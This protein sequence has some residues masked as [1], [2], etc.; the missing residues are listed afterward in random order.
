MLDV[1]FDDDSDSDPD[2]PRDHSF[3]REVATTRRFTAYNLVA[4]VMEMPTDEDLRIDM[5]NLLN[6]INYPLCGRN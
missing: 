6:R 2:R 1:E 3:A 5:E 4:H